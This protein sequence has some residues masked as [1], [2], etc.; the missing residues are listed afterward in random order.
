MKG[1]P[2]SGNREI[3]LGGFQNPGLW[4]P[5]YIVR[6][7]ESRWDFR[8]PD[9]IVTDSGIHYLESGIHGMESRIQDCPGFPYMGR[10]NSR[11]VLFT[12]TRDS[13]RR[14]YS[15]DSA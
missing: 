12:A 4:N 7:P 11:L 1:N 6:N 13:K 14:L 8:T 3:L 2:E 9:S 10:E 15:Q 5:E